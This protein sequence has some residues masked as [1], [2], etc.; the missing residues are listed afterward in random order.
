[1]SELHIFNHYKSLI[2]FQDLP[3][4][5]ASEIKVHVKPLDLA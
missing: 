3:K 5:I 2:S 1:M 4:V